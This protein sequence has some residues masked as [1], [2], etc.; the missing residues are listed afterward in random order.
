MELSQLRY[1]L[2]V[3]RRGNLSKAANDL[4]L[5]QP[6][7][8]RSIAKLEEELGQPVFER[9][10]RSMALTDAGEL[11][12]ARAQ[13]VVGIIDDT[14]SEIRDDG[15][16]GRLRVGAIPTIAPYLL[17][18]LLRDFSR[19]YPEVSVEVTEG[20]TVDLIKACD[21]GEL[22]LAILALPIETKHLDTEAMFEEELFLVMPKGH[23]LAK[24]TDISL[25][26]VENYP[27]VLLGEAHCLTGNVIS[28]C[29]KKSFQPVAVERTSQLATVQELVTLG[30][31]ISMIPDM[32]KRIDKDKRRVY[33]HVT[34]PIPMRTIAIA[35]NPYRFQSRVLEAFRESIRKYDPLAS[36]QG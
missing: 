13:D 12:V 16:T 20:V 25:A 8:S 35:W 1:F 30:H 17:P 24:K 28:V 22:D 26:E 27:F 5:S 34:N 7:L 31:G 23:E 33:R 32:A 3:A 9:R 29:R 21:Q 14:K 15:R 4:G 19:S 18:K 10:P 6:A 11:L 2:A 36:T